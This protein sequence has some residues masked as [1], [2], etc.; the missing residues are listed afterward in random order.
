[1]LRYFIATRN[2][3]DALNLKELFLSDER[4]ALDPRGMTELAGFLL[5][6]SEEGIA[7]VGTADAEELVNQYVA[8]LKGDDSDTDLAAGCHPGHQSGHGARR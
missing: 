8:S 5:D 6:L 2:V 1:M 3:E 7:G 4:V